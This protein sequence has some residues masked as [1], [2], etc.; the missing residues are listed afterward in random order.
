MASYTK[1][2]IDAA[3]HSDLAAF[4][5]SR[6]ETVR[7]KGCEGEPVLPRHEG[8]VGVDTGFGYVHSLAEADEEA[9]SVLPLLVV[10]AGRSALTRVFTKAAPS[11]ALPLSHNDYNTDARKNQYKQTLKNHSERFVHIPRSFRA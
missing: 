2:Q 10:F 7:R 8:S 1:Q 3:N 4:L 9:G 5:M 11:A 6:G